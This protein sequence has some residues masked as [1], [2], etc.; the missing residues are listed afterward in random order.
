MSEKQITLA[1][2]KRT[3][4]VSLLAYASVTGATSFP[5]VPFCPFGGPTGWMNRITGYDDYGG[6]NRY[7][8]PV[9]YPSPYYQPGWRP[10]MQP[11]PRCDPSRQTCFQRQ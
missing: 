10:V 1:V 7:P 4:L 6:Y 3:V 5:E 11:D 2:I 9:Y 8:P